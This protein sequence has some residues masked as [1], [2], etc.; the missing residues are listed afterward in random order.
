MP[1]LVIINKSTE[2]GGA[3][4][5]ALR[6]FRAHKMYLKNWDIQFLAQEGESK[7]E[8]EIH[9]VTKGKISEATNLFRLAVEKLI[10]LFYEKSKEIRFQFSMAN[11]GRDLA[12]IPMVQTADFIHLHWLYQGFISIR[13]MD[14]LFGMGI[15]VV[16]TLHDM[17]PFTGGCHYPGTCNHFKDSCGNCP[18]LRNPATDDLSSKILEKKQK[19]FKKYPQVVFVSCSEWLARTARESSVLRNHRIEVIPNTIDINVFSPG[20]KLAA[21]DKLGIEKGKF[22]IL[23]GAANVDDKRKGFYYLQQALDK[24]KS[25]FPAETENI[26]LMVFGKSGAHMPGGYRVYDQNLVSN[27]S[28][29][30]NI[31]RAADVFVL[32]SLED[33]LPNTIMESFACGTPVVA[34]NSGGIPEMIDHRQNGYLAQYKNT[35]DLVKGILWI[36]GLSHEELGKSGRE[37]V[38]NKYHPEK[39]SQAYKELYLSLKK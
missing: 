31:Y 19:L 15:P 36:K 38:L 18:F 6:L 5:A 13:G 9:I 16:W 4:I 33:N 24:L 35:D 10:F 1:K 29:L 32:P 7:G 28:D 14:R 37:K 21:R 2:T 27:E 26:E 8:E 25:D 11:T 3:A 20:D 22:I 12:N 23:F 39:I 30:V 34:F 17:W